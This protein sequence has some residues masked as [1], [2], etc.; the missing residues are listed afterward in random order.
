MGVFAQSWSVS[1]GISSVFS[2]VVVLGVLFVSFELIF[3]SY[4]SCDS[5]CFWV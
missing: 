5:W 4:L 2:F 1:F 3:L